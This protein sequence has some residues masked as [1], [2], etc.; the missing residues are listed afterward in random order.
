MPPSSITTIASR[1]LN[2]RTTL[3]RAVQ[4]AIGHNQPLTPSS[5]RVFAGR[6]FSNLL[7]QIPTPTATDTNNLTTG[8]IT[9]RSPYQCSPYRMMSS[10]DKTT[11]SSSSQTPQSD[12]DR[13]EE[14]SKPSSDDASPDDN[15]NE[16]GDDAED[17]ETEEQKLQ[18]QITT[19]K[20]QLLRAL[21]EQENIR[22]IARRDVDNSKSYA[23]TSFAKSLLDTSDNL[24]RALEAVPEEHRGDGDNS[25]LSNLYEGIQMTDSGLTKALLKNGLVKFGTVGDVFDPNRHEALFEYVE[26]GKEAGTVGQVMKVG[27][28]LNKR[29]IRPAEVG[30]I[31]KP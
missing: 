27:F 24:S 1:S 30:I 29:V 7:H 12:D 15:D 10:N 31:K 3:F 11:T 19:L 5:P 25:V 9:R 26:E 21:A 23:V 14:T 20:D 22:R 17:E 6:Q 4:S 2:G 8:I 16:E 18:L 13:T 28:E